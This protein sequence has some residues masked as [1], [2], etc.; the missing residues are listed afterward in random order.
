M[1]FLNNNDYT[2]IRIAFWYYQYLDLNI[3]LPNCH[4]IVSNE[5]L[6]RQHIERK[7]DHDSVK[8]S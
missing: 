3:V 5:P 6:H 4:S 8:I 7:P 1:W 2:G